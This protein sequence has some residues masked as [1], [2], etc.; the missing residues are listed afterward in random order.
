MSETPLAYVV[1]ASVG[2]KLFIDEEFSRQADAL[3]VLLT[4]DPPAR[5]HVPDLFF[6]ECA[7]I[8]WKHVRR[9][10]YPVE[11]ARDDLDVLY[12]LALHRTSTYSLLRMAFAIAIDQG[13]TAY[14]ASYVALAHHLGVPL[15]T[16]DQRLVQRLA[17][18][19][20]V[21]HGIGYFDIPDR[22]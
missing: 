1:D 6:I 21:V 16:A 12:S 2:I 9:Y 4:I 11:K 10:N 18:T 19:V 8:L 7:N 22:E 15:V 17:A 13:I 3:F 5:L 20:Y 14:D